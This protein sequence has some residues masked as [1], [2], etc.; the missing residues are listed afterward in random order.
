MTSYAGTYSHPAYLDMIITCDESG[1]L[2]IVRSKSQWKIRIELEHVSGEY[3]LARMNSTVNPGGFVFKDAWP[4]EFKIGVSGTP[5]ALGAR[6]E[7]ATG[8]EK[9]WFRRD[10]KI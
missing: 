10:S 3:F 4:A 2:T 6:L 5:V 9:I 7:K 8:A 1:V